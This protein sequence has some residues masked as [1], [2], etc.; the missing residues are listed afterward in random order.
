MGG[1]WEA[2]E[3]GV[4]FYLHVKNIQYSA[5]AYNWKEGRSCVGKGNVVLTMRYI[6]IY[7]QVAIIIV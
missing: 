3:K 5:T 7:L 4:C 2:E 6:F 1:G